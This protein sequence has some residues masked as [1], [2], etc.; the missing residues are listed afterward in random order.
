MAKKPK[1][2]EV[3]QFVLP[4]TIFEVV[5]KIPYDIQIKQIIVNGKKGVLNVG[6]ICILPEGIQLTPPNHIPPK[7]KE[8]IGNLYFQ[9]YSPDK[10]IFLW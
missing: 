1:D 7:I 6:T 3:P 9:S 5:T 10:K 4:N 2:V 8:R